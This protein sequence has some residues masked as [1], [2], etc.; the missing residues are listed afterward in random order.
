MTSEIKNIYLKVIISL[1]AI[2]LMTLSFTGHIDMIGEDYAEQGL[3]RTLVTYTI[4]RGLNGMISV[5]QGTEVAVEPAGIGLVFTPGEILDPVNDLIEQFSTVVLVS[6]ASLGIQRILIEM[7]SWVWFSAIV[8]LA[9]AVAIFAVWKPFYFSLHRRQ[10]IYRLAIVLVIIR[11][12]V[13]MIAIVNEGMYLAFLQDEYETSKS[14]LELSSQNIE[15]MQSTPDPKVIQT[16]QSLMEKLKQF[17][18][19]A[20]NSLDVSSNLEDLKELAAEISEHVLNMIVVFV[21]QT[22][23]SP[24]LFLWLSYRLI[25]RLINSTI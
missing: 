24:L 4:A 20:S 1:A 3:K 6:G 17:Y 5:A 18:Q 21:V 25:V 22:I 11:F 8:A 15:Q 13:P 23:I 16:D 7:T 2:L 10:F 12:V 19:S 9:V 14:G